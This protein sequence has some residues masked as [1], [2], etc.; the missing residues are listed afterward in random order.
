MRMRLLIRI[1]CGAA[2]TKAVEQLLSNLTPYYAGI[3][4]EFSALTQLREKSSGT[5]GFSAHDHA[6][7]IILWPKLVPLL[8]DYPDI[9]IEIHIDYE[10]IDIV[11]ERYD[12]GL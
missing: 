10:L 1:T 12:A 11:S 9:A 4:A 7:T 8:R 5:L 6:A 2:P 3:E